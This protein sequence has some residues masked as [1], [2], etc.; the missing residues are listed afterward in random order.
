MA[1]RD[2]P[3][4]A[5]VV[6]GGVP[7]VPATLEFAKFLA[8]NASRDS[9]QFQHESFDYS[10]QSSSPMDA[11]ATQIKGMLKRATGFI[12][13]M[14]EYA[15]ER[16]IHRLR[17]KVEDFVVKGEQEILHVVMKQVNKTLDKAV[18]MAT[19]AAEKAEAKEAESGLSNISS[20]VLAQISDDHLSE[21]DQIPE[22]IFGAFVQVTEMLDAFQAILPTC[23]NNLK[24]ART[25]VS[26]VSSV[27]DS[28]FSTFKKKGKPIFDGVAKAYDMLWI[29]YFCLLAPITLG[30]L[31]Y[32]FWASGWFG[33]PAPDAEADSAQDPPEGIA[34]KCKSV[35]AS[36]CFCLTG[37][38][39]GDMCFWS[40]LLL[41]QVG[42]LLLFLVAIL[43]CILAGV[44]AFIASGCAQIY[45]LGD[46][47]ACTNTLKMLQ[48]FIETFKVGNPD[49]FDI[50]NACARNTLMTC[51]EL[52]PKMQSS[53]MLTVL[54]GLLG[55]VFSFQMLVDS[56]V[57]HERANMR[58][59]IQ[60]ADAAKAASA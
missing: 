39:G 7:A 58:K 50:E 60:D 51:A 33:G 38:C 56:S 17:E 22:K 35:C 14:E 8:W 31:Y 10:G 37:W 25:F 29:L 20:L 16:G 23:I 27:L 42:V 32:G 30:I 4:A 24:Q 48:Q 6:K 2:D 46:E 59:L 18:S 52:G 41:A 34:A 28:T 5:A 13:A 47:T 40:V 1:L 12:K 36:C 54:G 45:L 55:A 9:D 11:F 26:S 3:A 43:L 53:A 49:G 15:S 19:K 44:K 21:E 57:L